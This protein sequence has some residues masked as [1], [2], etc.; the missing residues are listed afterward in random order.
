[1]TW[2]FL[3][4]GLVLLVAGA[5]SL[6]RGS[7]AIAKR[8]GLSELLIGLTVVSF[9]TSAPELAVSLR[10]ALGGN[11]AVALGNV[12][13]SNIFN[14]FVILGVSA[15]ITPLAVHFRVLRQEMPVLVVAT[16]VF[17][18]LLHF[19]GGV[20]RLV[21]IVFFLALV[22]YTVRMVRVERRTAAGTPVSLDGLEVPSL[23]LPVAIFYVV[24]GLGLLILGANWLVD[25]AVT[26]ARGLGVSEAIIGLTIVAA[27]TSLPEVAASV[28]AAL[29][30][31]ADLAIGNVVGSNLF[32]ILCIVGV[33]ASVHPLS[34]AGISPVD[35]GAMLLAL[36]ALIPLA[37]T[38]AKLTR[39]EG[40]VLLGGYG[41]Y[42][43]LVWP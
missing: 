3:L 4:L 19:G 29:R 5:E 6:V 39:W 33:T 2:L 34:A 20:G 14:I 16:F 32:N 27:G 13:G 40:L 31:S 42:L 17:A 23:R 35:L 12:I 7:S 8:L 37:W 41:V 38:G 1:M 22:A 11:D 21:G 36:V 9:G 15:A 30:K 18:A 26:I 25:S 24:V 10:S 28:V 43:W